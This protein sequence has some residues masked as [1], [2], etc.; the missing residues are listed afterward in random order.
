MVSLADFCEPRCRP[1]PSPQSQPSS[2]WPRRSASLRSQ[3]EEMLREI[4]FVYDATRRIRESMIK[5]AGSA[6][7][8]QVLTHWIAT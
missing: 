5:E 2:A 8:C 6:G 1:Y 4:A 3:A 7:Q